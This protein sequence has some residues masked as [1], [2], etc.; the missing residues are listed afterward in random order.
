MDHCRRSDCPTTETSNDADD[1]L[2]QRVQNG[3][4]EAFATLFTRYHHE[5]RGFILART[6]DP[7]AADDITNDVFAKVYR[8]IDRY[9]GGSFRGWI[10]QIARTTVIDYQRAHRPTTTLNDHPD[11]V[12]PVPAPDAAA[13]AT[14]AREHLIAALSILPPVPRRIIELRLKG[15]PLTDI[16]ADLNMELSAVKSAQ[17]RAFKKLRTH[18][19]N[20]CADDSSSQR[21]PS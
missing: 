11:L 2:V 10:Y 8:A 7:S 13:I 17:H 21:T 4:D 14:E 19:H 6:G 12:S 15:F 1:D 20:P 5:L 9:H 3:D 16:C 18:L